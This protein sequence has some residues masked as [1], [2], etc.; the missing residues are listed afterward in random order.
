MKLLFLSFVGLLFLSCSHHQSS[1]DFEKRVN[2]QTAENLSQLESNLKDLLNMH[3][4]LTE[5]QKDNISKRLRRFIATQRQLRDR[6]EKLLEIGLGDAIYASDASKVHWKKEVT[7][8][9]EQKAENTRSTVQ[10]IHDI[11]KDPP[12]GENFYHEFPFLL[13]EVR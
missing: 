8:L 9:Y 6:E 10:D 4:E 11:T 13:R 5:D 12:V 2:K 3:S 1:R 7:K